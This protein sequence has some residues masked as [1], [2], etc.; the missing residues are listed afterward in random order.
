M[1]RAKRIVVFI[2]V[3]S[4]IANVIL[5]IPTASAADTGGK[6]Y[7]LN[8]HE[9]DNQ[10]I[11]VPGGGWWDPDDNML[12]NRNK[13]TAYGHYTGIALLPGDG[14]GVTGDFDL[15][16]YEDY[17][18]EEEVVSSYRG[19]GKLEAVVVQQPDSNSESAYFVRVLPYQGEG[20]DA[21]NEMNYVIESDSHSGELYENNPDDDPGPL[22]VGE[23]RR[24]ALIAGDE[25]GTFFGGQGNTNGEPPLLNVYSSFLYEGGSYDLSIPWID[26]SSTHLSYHIVRGTAAVPQGALASGEIHVDGGLNEEITDFTPDETGWYGIMVL[27]HNRDN[28]DYQEYDILL[29]GGHQVNAYPKTQLVAPG[30]DTIYDIEVIAEGA[31]HPIDLDYQWI[32]DV[33]NNVNVIIETDTIYPEGN[34]IDETFISVETADTTDPG[35]Y[36][37]SISAQSRDDAGTEDYTEVKLIVEDQENFY[38]DGTPD[39]QKVGIGA[40]FGYQIDVSAINGF[41]DDVELSVIDVSPPTAELS[42]EFEETILTSPYP[43]ETTL[44]IYTSTEIEPNIYEIT[45]EGVGGGLQHNTTVEL[46]VVPGIDASI[47]SPMENELISESYT[48]QADASYTEGDIISLEL[49]F[50]GN[51]SSLGTISTS[52]STETGLWEREINTKGYPDGFSTVKATAIADDGALYTSESVIFETTNTPPNP[53]IKQPPDHEYVTGVIEIMVETDERVSEVRF[54]IDDQAWQPLTGGPPEWSAVWDTTTVSDGMHDI[55]VE[56]TNEAGLTGQSGTKVYVDNNPP[57]I[58]IV[59]PIN[60]ETVQSRYT[61]QA[62]AEDT[63]RVERVNLTVFGSTSSMIYNAITGY[64]ERSIRT[65]TVPDGDYTAYMQAWD[66]VGHESENR[67]VSFQVANTPPS[68]TI[69]SPESGE[70]LQSTHTLI[71]EVESDFLKKVEYRINQG[72]WQS[73]D[74][75]G[76]SE[77][78]SAE[79]DTTVVSDGSYSITF[80]AVDEV[81][82]VTEITRDVKVDNNPP[83]GTIIEPLGGEF[84][85]GTHTFRISAS[86]DLGVSSVVINVFG[87]EYTAFYNE[88][89]GYYEYSVNV[90]PIADGDYTVNATI[91]DSAGWTYTTGNVDFKVDNTVPVI[92]IENPDPNSYVEGHV[93]IEADV[94]E[95]YLDSVEV[96]IDEG[97][98]D[99]MEENGLW[100][101]EWDTMGYSEGEHKISVRATDESGRANIR[102]IYVIVDNELPTGSIVSPSSEAYIEGTYTFQISASDGNGVHSVEIDVFDATH[103]AAY[104]QG[105]GFY[106]HTFRT[107][108]V[109]D[110]VYDA[111]VTVTDN[112]GKQLTLGPITFFVDN[113]DPSVDIMN[114][115]QGDYVSGIVE[116]NAVTHD[117]FLK[118]VHYRINEG[119]WKEM[120]IEDEH[121]STALWDTMDYDE[122]NHRID[123]RAVD[124]IGKTAIDSI[125]VIVDNELPTGFIASPYSGEYINGA[126]TFQVAAEDENGIDHVRVEVFNENYLAEYNTEIGM[127]EVIVITTS[128]EDGSYNINATIEDNAGRQTELSDLTFHV[129]NNHPTLTITEPKIGNIL[130]GDSD[131][132]VEAEDEFLSEVRYRVDDGDWINMEHAQNSTWSDVLDTSAYPDGEHILTF[133]S[134]DSGGLSTTQAIEV[135]FDNTKPKGKIIAP[136]DETFVQERVDFIVDAEDSV[137]VREVMINFLD[138]DDENASDI[139]EIGTHE[140]YYDHSRGTYVFEVVTHRYT[141]GVARFNAT[142][143]NMAGFRTYLNEVEFFIDNDPPEIAYQEPVQEQFVSEIVQITAEVDDGPYIPEVTYRVDERAWNSMEREGSIWSAEWDSTT[144][145]DGEHTITIRAR[146][147]IGHVTL[148]SIEV[149]VDNHEPKISI[150][151]PVQNEF[152]EGDLTIQIDATDRV[153]IDYVMVDIFSLVREEPHKGHWTIEAIYNPSSGYYEATLD[154]SIEEED[155]YWNATA[156]TR[157]LSGKISITETVRFRVVNNYPELTIHSPQHGEYVSGD[158]LINVTVEDAFPGPA[159]YS[160]NEGGWRPI[161][162]PWDTT[163]H[164]DGEHRLDIKATDQAGNSVVRTIRVTVIN[165]DPEVTIVS[166]MSDQ[167][168]EGWFQFRVNARHTVKVERVEA[169]IFESTQEL[170]YD[171]DSGYYVYELDTRNLD[172]GTYNLSATVMDPIGNMAETETISFHID[173]NSPVIDIHS[174]RNGEYI[175]DIVKLNVTVE[176]EFLRNVMYS[177]DDTGFVPITDELNTTRLS[178]G[179]HT[180][181]V[182]ATDRAGHVT[183]R[184]VTVI[185]DNVA[186]SIRM[187]KPRFEEV[188]SG[189]EELEVFVDSEVLKV[190]IEFPDIETPAIPMERTTDP[191]I[192]SYVLDT[193]DLTRTDG[194]GVFLAIVRVEDHAGNEMDREFEINIDNE[195]PKIDMIEPVD[196]LLNKTTVAGST[197]FG[198]NVSSVSAVEKIQINIG[199]EGWQD[200]VLVENDTYRYIWDAAE[201][202]DGDYTYI[203]RTEDRAGNVKQYSGSVSVDNPTDYWAAFQN[204]LPGIY[205]ILIL[206]LLIFL[207]YLGR[208]EVKQRLKRDEKDDDDSEKTGFMASLFRTKKEKSKK[209]EKKKAAKLKKKSNKDKK[210]LTKLR[211]NYDIRKRLNEG[212]ILTLSEL[213]GKTEEDLLKIKGIGKKDKNTIKEKLNELGLSLKDKKD[214]KNKEKGNEKDLMGSVMDAELPSDK[215]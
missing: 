141:D 3:C 210:D 109:S 206:I 81:G 80:R 104:N 191:N 187:Q 157:D 126:F 192:F 103:V 139:G 140:M 47:F 60:D 44:H 58:N 147:D 178:D 97:D 175:R 158:V 48:F 205:F 214:I 50:G 20:Y 54:R 159:Y 172:D 201:V 73:M 170:T 173:N 184:Q 120:D 117:I 207:V 176:D 181:T 92:S 144:I 94:T 204:N 150:L 16:V 79:W 189:V 199:G 156:Y 26:E 152:V 100:I 127:Y 134:V 195:A 43:K 4:L 138:V 119:V 70:T 27:N 91:Q 31:V 96:R 151:N 135:I 190:T 171:A 85:S 112:S 9:P 69:L 45:V 51:M 162:V 166:P 84:I 197:T 12:P 125:D 93:S 168:V 142:I 98:W 179:E 188:I 105:T 129:N 193:T 118:E 215:D 122:G 182:R 87:E 17:D 46:E 130:S 101:Y 95:L 163:G 59:S 52:Y 99:E 74:Y 67:S 76:I 61:F 149:T 35:E 64:Y 116:I 137:G 183:E 36:T 40:N 155:G 165:T 42:Y 72:G 211:I 30:M 53:I 123:V 57:V 71:A 34:T 2:V 174:P 83:A 133:E 208:K 78:Y 90:E 132:I 21:N 18:F 55:T 75:D 115:T 200:M 41:E 13:I 63:V 167:F 11:Q 39:H 145:E 25:G 143:V 82:H 114:P 10:Y 196:S 62:L 180:I 38:L 185:A 88:V 113:T 5:F 212:G 186:P 131:V 136:I 77:T 29:S 102:T 124:E 19:L 153:G 202:E 32:G 154:T 33:P 198:L 161:I 108:A 15:E 89:T 177:V 66:S 146:D 203:I 148:N 49:T 164:S 8:N 160:V 169:E 68:M 14:G 56:A 106:E 28:P 1:Q 209:D 37:L 107:T 110:G 121:N 111:N 128:V 22:A 7:T 194:S 86:D 24:S 213:T 23:T 6:S 65:S